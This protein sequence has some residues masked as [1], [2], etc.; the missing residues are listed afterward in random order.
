[1][2]CHPKLEDGMTDTVKDTV[3]PETPT[4]GPAALIDPADVPNM[5][6]ADINDVTADGL[7]EDGGPKRDMAEGLAQASDKVKTDKV[8]VSPFNLGPGGMIA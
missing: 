4:E 6:K 7:K 3:A 5:T 8:E 1:M 2:V